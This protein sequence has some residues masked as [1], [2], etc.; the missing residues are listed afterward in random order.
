MIIPEL[1]EESKTFC[2]RGVRLYSDDED[3]TLLRYLGKVSKES[4]LKY[5]PGKTYNALENHYR[6]TKKRQEKKNR[7]KTPDAAPAH[8]SA[9]GLPKSDDD[10]TLGACATCSNGRKGKQFDT[11]VCD[12]CAPPVK[13]GAK[14]ASPE[15]VIAAKKTPGCTGKRYHGDLKIP[16]SCATQKTEYY[17]AWNICRKHGHIPYPEALALENKS[18]EKV[19]AKAPVPKSGLVVRKQK[20]LPLHQH[21]K[22]ASAESAAETP[23]HDNVAATQPQSETRSPLLDPLRIVSGLTVRQVKPDGGRQ[24]FGTGTVT[25][26]HGEICEV[27]NGGKTHHI[28]AACLEI[29]TG[30][31]AAKGAIS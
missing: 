17:R 9:E 14:T 4:L 25:A 21:P 28:L 12:E 18:K 6:R 10:P 11:K 27:R 24:M 22:T 20:P 5:F 26:R 19:P 3:D 15:K 8:K 16:F 2:R 31:D 30:K 29:A 7:A 23:G 1:E 13:R